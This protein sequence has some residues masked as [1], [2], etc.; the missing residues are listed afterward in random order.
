[1]DDHSQKGSH[2]AQASVEAY[3][4]YVIQQL[5]G[6]KGRND[7]DVVAFILKDWIGDHKDELKEYGIDVSKWKSKKR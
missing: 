7:S 1:M 2:K 4:W 6:I 3:T 5:V